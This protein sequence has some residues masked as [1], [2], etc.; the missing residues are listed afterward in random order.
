MRDYT[1]I[2]MWVC[3]EEKID[4]G[5]KTGAVHS[6]DYKVCK[7]VKELARQVELG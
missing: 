7:E 2:S 1:N 5:K 6:G 3:Q 4:I